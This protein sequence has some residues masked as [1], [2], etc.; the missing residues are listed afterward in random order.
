MIEVV[1]ELPLAERPPA[2]TERADAARN[3]ERILRAAEALIAER[4]V[5]HFSMHDVAK[6][7]CVGTGTM[8][9]RFGDRAGLVFALL[10][11]SSRE[12][13]EAFLRGPAPLGPGAPPAERLHAFGHRFLEILDRDAPLLA[14]GAHTPP[15]LHGPYPAYRLHLAF[16]LEEAAPGLDV[17]YA[18]EGLL[19][20]L[21]PRLHLHLREERGWPLS[22]LQAGWTTL[23]DGWLAAAR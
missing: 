21:D 2:L 12:F 23:V 15:I 17:D 14:A 19:A 13:Q 4:G 10:D 3:R 7:A 18:V 9:R 6:A 16:L 11:E 20:S 1:Q 22:R 5:E 8:Y